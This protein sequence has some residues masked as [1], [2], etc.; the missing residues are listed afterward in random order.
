MIVTITL[1]ADTL[2]GEAPVTVLFGVVNPRAQLGEPSITLSWDGTNF[3]LE[4]MRQYLRELEE[5]RDKY[6]EIMRALERK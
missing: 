3:D 6:R 2:Q 1:D 5:T 4:D